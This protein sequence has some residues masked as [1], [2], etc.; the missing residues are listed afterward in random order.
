[1]VF[2]LPMGMCTLAPMI[3]STCLMTLMDI[4]SKVRPATGTG[5]IWGIVMFPSL[6]TTRLYWAFTLPQRRIFT[7]SPGPTT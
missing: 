3:F 4:F 2:S 6:S 1:M 5:P 7:S